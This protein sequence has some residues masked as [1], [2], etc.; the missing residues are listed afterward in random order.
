MKRKIVL[1]DVDGVIANF[2]HAF[3]H[4]LEL[5]SGIRFDHSV[6]T[7]WNIQESPALVELHKER[8][9][10]FEEVWKEVG[11]P[12]FCYDMLPYEDAIPGVKTLLDKDVDVYA[13]TAPFWSSNT[14]MQERTDW[15]FK[16]FGIRAK[17]VVQTHAKH[18]VFGHVF[19]D[20]K[21]AHIEEWWH[22]WSGSDRVALLWDAPYNRKEERFRRVTGWD[23]VH[24]AIEGIR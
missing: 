15:L 18:L 24:K 6:V 13:L 21:P 3:L 5:L 20:D 17:N 12:G 4:K 22:R 2:T 23:E 14:W 11:S 10:L 7:E 9:G 8:P 1:I 19:V 16:H